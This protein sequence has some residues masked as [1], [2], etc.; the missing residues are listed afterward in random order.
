[1]SYEIEEVYIT[2][3]SR[4]PARSARREPFAV[5]KALSHTFR[6]TTKAATFS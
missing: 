4:N 3:S 2:T 1:M 6:F 5:T